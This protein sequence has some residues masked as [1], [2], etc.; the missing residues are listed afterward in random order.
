MTEQI[1]QKDN[2]NIAIATILS[3]LYPGLGQIYNGEFSKGI[4]FIV[5]AV[6]LIFSMM[7][8]IGF[9]LY[10]AFWIYNIIDAYHTAKKKEKK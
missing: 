9:I 6:L 4:M 10:P 7:V 2:K 8:L 3:V 5:I 1:E